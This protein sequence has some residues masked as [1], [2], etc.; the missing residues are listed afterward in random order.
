[1]GALLEC[2]F[3]GLHLGGA[4][5]DYFGNL[6]RSWSAWGKLLI[7]DRSV[8]RADKTPICIHTCTHLAPFRN[9]V[10]G[11]H[12]AR[13]LHDAACLGRIPRKN[14]RDSPQSRAPGVPRQLDVAGSSA[15]AERASQWGSRRTCLRP[16][17]TFWNFAS[18]LA[19]AASCVKAPQLTPPTTRHV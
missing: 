7:H 8:P 10:S 9:D 11:G 5:G 13:N 2:T 6:A 19:A 3:L 17:S 16:A 18:F 4:R 14:K 15:K 12:R 1:M